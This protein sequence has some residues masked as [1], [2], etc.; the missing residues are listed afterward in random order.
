[1]AVSDNRTSDFSG[2]ATNTRHN[3]AKLTYSYRVPEDASLV[4][5]DALSLGAYQHVEGITILRNVE[6]CSPNE[7]APRHTRY[8]IRIVNVF[9]PAMINDVFLHVSISDNQPCMAYR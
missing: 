8:T 2:F 7:T 4:L 5:R 3:V 9:L 6:L 1:M